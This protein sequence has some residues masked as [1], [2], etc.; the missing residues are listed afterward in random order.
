MLPGTA[1]A[2][3]LRKQALR[4]A[5]IARSGNGDAEQWVE[6]L[7]G[8]RAD[9]RKRQARASKLRI[10]ESIVEE[11]TRRRTSRIR[12]DRFTQGVVPGALF[13]EEPEFGGRVRLRLELRDP[14]PGELG[15]LVL[16][17]KDLLTGELAV[18]GTSSVGRG[19]FGGA[20]TLRLEDGRLVDL[21]PVKAP[22]P[23]VDLAIGELWSAPVLGGAA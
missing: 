2:G 6:Q 7:F 5:R 17:L 8:T 23:V 3:A 21:D 12:I 18:G 14:A 16:V 19:R 11:G 22:D 1:V 15:L 13:D 4:I 20:A 10:A 9:T